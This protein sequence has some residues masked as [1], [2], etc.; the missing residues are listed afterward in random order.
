VNGI[1]RNRSFIKNKQVK[2]SVLGDATLRAGDC[3]FKRNKYRDAVKFYD[4]AIHSKFPGFQ[5]ALFQKAIIEGLRGNTTDKLLVLE[6]LISKY[7]RSEYADDA[8]FQLGTTY[9]EINKPARATDALKRLVTDYPNSGLVNNALLRLGLVA[10]NSGNPQAAI[11]YY[12]QVFSHSPEPGE[13][14]A[15]MTALR[16]IYIK[17]MGDSDA[18]AAFLETVPGYKLDNI[19]RDTLAFDAAETAYESGNYERAVTSFTDYVRKFPNGV[20]ILLAR[21]HRAESYAVLKQYAQA[22]KDYDWIIGKGPGKYFVDALKKGAAIAYHFEKDF[23]KAYDYYSQ[24]ES[25]AT[26]MQDRFEAQLGS[27]RSAY[28]LGDEAAV[29]SS[30]RKVANNPSASDEQVAT[31]EFYLAKIA[32]D[33]EDYNLAMQSFQQVLKLSDNE[34]T[35]EA[36]YLIAMIYYQQ[37]DLEKAKQQCLDN[38]NENSGYPYWVGKSLLLLSDVFAEQGDLFS[39][40]TVLEALIENYETQD[41]DILPT[42]R[43]KLDTLNQKAAGSSRLETETDNNFMDDGNGGNK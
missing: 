7:P 16:E 39:A 1:R 6:S 5:Y 12:K 22:L 26:S 18:F 11:D 42:A 38:N 17:D 32:F 15:A 3:L 33:K 20:K 35:A 30:A 8:I 4:D 19:G 43:Q 28:R 21:Y 2:E 31:A 10:Y 40:K 36:R 25:L 27:M 24:F 29:Q 13:A 34:Q 41:D 37:R 23:R 14:D 9:Q